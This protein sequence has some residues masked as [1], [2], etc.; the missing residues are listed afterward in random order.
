MDRRTQKILEEHEKMKNLKRTVIDLKDLTEKVNTAVVED[1]EYID[2]ITEEGRKDAVSIQNIIN[3]LAEV[4][5]DSFTF[6]LIVTVV[7]LGGLLFVGL[8]FK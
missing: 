2:K 8:L 4:K 3:K 1:T 7:L 5:K 6:T